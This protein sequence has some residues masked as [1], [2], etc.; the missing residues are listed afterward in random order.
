MQADI[1]LIR[2]VFT[3]ILVIAGALIQPVP[4]SVVDQMGFPGGSR[5]L[6]ALIG[7]VLAAGI[8]FFDYEFA[9]HRSK[10]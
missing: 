5:L 7:F 1:I 3:I 9:R 2:T 10:P 6:S 4:K 8:I